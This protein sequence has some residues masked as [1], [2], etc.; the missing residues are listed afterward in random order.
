ML[1][2][3]GCF[4]MLQVCVWS[5]AVGMI[6]VRGGCKGLGLAGREGLQA[7]HWSEN[8]RS[9]DW[10]SA[11]S[12]I[13]AH[14]NGLVCVVGMPA[15]LTAPCVLLYFMYMGCVMEQLL[16]ACG[17]R[18]CDPLCQSMLVAPGLAGGLA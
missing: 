10:Q 4:T 12:G 18:C 7:V 3:V 13:C 2:V 17:T 15:A 9:E 8:V 14:S 5:L 16:A 6:V 11:S 1:Q